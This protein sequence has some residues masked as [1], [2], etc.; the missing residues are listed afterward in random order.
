[1]ATDEY[2]DYAICRLLAEMCEFD[3]G[4]DK[5]PVA[6]CAG[7][8]EIVTREKIAKYIATHPKSYP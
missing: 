3:C 8:N 4:C 6:N 7:E 1:M 2:R 5:C